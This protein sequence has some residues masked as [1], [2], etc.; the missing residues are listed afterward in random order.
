MDTKF[1]TSFI[2]KRPIVSANPSIRAKHP[3]NLLS[4]IGTFIF[5]LALIALGGEF[6]YKRY[7]N[8]KLTAMNQEL[9][10]AQASIKDDLTNKFI[11]LDA[12]LRGAETLLQGHVA[13]SLLFATLQNQT[14]KS[15]QFSDLTYQTS[16]TGDVTVSMKGLANSYNAVALQ[17]GIFSENKYIKNV[18]FSDMN[19]DPKGQVLFSFRATIDSELIAQRKTK[20]VLTSTPQ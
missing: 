20:H 3:L 11:R 9:I 17:A 18:L 15:I 2:P 19:L 13:T 7:M 5:I 10:E 1:Q 4:L 14:V 12:R 16:P 6:A 8:D